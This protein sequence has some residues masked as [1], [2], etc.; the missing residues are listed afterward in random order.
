M[1]GPS[2][3]PSPVWLPICTSL[4]GT[5]H[6]HRGTPFQ[7]ASAIKR[8]G[9]SGEIVLLALSDGAGS[10]SHADVGAQTVVR[11]WLESFTG[12]LQYCPNPA[13]VLAENAATTLHTL[14]A[15][16]RNSAESDALAFEVSPSNFSHSGKIT[17]QHY[18]DFDGKPLPELRTRIKVNLRTLLVEVFDHSEGPRIQLLY[19]K[20]RFVGK[21]HPGRSGMEKFS[22]KLR[23]LGLNESTIGLGPDKETLIRILAAA[24]LDEK[25]RS[26]RQSSR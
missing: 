24:G 19:F 4:P 15:N 13:T 17:F 21:T 2:S 9:A 18:D 1:D 3:T 20:E 16:I 6:R 5:A 22:S 10:A 8:L 12:L 7:D 14:L 25:L 23:K 26:K 11:H